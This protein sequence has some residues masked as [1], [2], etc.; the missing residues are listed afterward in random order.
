MTFDRKADRTG[1][2]INKPA[3]SKV[4]GAL[5]F[6]KGVGYCIPIPQHLIDSP[7]FRNLSLR[8][9]RVL[10]G[11]VSE[12]CAHNGH[13]NGDLIVPYDDLQGRGIRR[14]AILP[15]ILELQALGLIAVQRG[16]KS[17]G[18]RTRRGNGINAGCAYDA[19]VRIRCQ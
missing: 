11:I 19:P 1:R 8:A 9:R 14:D 15:A 6:P 16:V 5:G 13:R 10:D 18:S 2:T 7:A 4:S 3:R 12:W 17:F